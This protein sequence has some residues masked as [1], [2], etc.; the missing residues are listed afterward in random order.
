[1]LYLIISMLVF[2]LM[3]IC[4]CYAIIRTAPLAISHGYGNGESGGALHPPL[5]TRRNSALLFKPVLT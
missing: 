2:V 4:A 1:M 5:Q 3:N